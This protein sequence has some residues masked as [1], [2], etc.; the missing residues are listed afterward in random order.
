M[1]PSLKRSEFYESAEMKLYNP[2]KQLIREEPSQRKTSFASSSRTNQKIKYFL[3]YQE[4]SLDLKKM[5][6]IIKT[7]KEKELKLSLNKIN[8]KHTKQNKI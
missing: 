2:P 6:N 3:N 5:E 8:T 7:K 1:L 4:L